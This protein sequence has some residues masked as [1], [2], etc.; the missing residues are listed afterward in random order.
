[1]R[2][3]FMPILAETS[4]IFPLDLADIANIVLKRLRIQKYSETT[5]KYIWIVFESDMNMIRKFINF[6]RI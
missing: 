1:M 3:D 4:S 5:L 6:L 2:C